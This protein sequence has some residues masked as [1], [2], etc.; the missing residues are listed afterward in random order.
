M[1][2]YSRSNPLSLLSALALGVLLVSLSGCGSSKIG[3]VKGVIT[4]D[5]APV[6]GAAVA[7]HP[8]EGRASIGRTDADGRYELGYLKNEAGA[9]IGPHKVTISTKIYASEASDA[10]G[11]P[12]MVKG[13]PETMPRRFST[14]AKSVLSAEVK[15]GSNK[16]DFSLD[17]EE[18]R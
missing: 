13:Q 6:A 17:S 11:N 9:I 10:D 2:L 4:M 3:T 7:F 15:A 14:L 16:I 1:S 12:T 18:Q 8:S 5:D